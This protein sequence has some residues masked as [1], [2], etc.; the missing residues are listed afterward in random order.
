MEQILYHPAFH[1]LVAGGLVYGYLYS[2]YW[3][4]W[5]EDTGEEGH[6]KD[7]TRCFGMDIEP[8][9]MA[10]AAFALVYYV[11]FTRGWTSKSTIFR[12]KTMPVKTTGSGN[13]ASEFQACNVNND[14]LRF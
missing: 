4:K 5:D 13:F 10:I 7:D 1:G 14:Y 2:Q 9:Y 3:V 6:W 11:S 8:I 12:S